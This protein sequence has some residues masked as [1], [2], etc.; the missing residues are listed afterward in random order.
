MK[1][2][3]TRR[4]GV[5]IALIAMAVA[6]LAY[7]DAQGFAG[8]VNPGTVEGAQSGRS[9]WASEA[10]GAITR[11]NLAGKLEA[12]LGDAFGGVW[13]EPTTAQLH[14]GVTSA[15][16]RRLAES[17]A[18]QVGHPDLLAVT[19]V[20]STWA[21]LD[22]AQER[23]DRRLADLMQ[24]AEVATALVAHR[25]AV[26]IE[27]G[28]SVPPSRRAALERQAAKDSV[29]VSITTDPHAEIRLIPHAQ[30]AAFKTKQA[31]CD[32]TIVGG[33]TITGPWVTKAGTEEE[34]E[35]EIEAEPEFEEEEIEGAKKVRN[36]CTAGVAAI[37][38]KPANGTEATKT[39]MLT[40]GHCINENEDGGGI[41]GKWTAYDKM[42]VP[43]GANELGSATTYLDA[44]TD[45]GVIEVKV[46]YWAKANVANPV[47]PGIAFWEAVETKPLP[48]I[49]QRNP[50]EK[51][52]TCLSGQVTIS[53]C[54]GEITTIDRSLPA[55]KVTVKN[56]IEVKGLKDALGDSGGPWFAEDEYKNGKAY[57]E[58]THVGENTGTK[59]LVFQSL[60]TSFEKLKN[61]KSLDL[62]LLT[63]A[64]ENRKHP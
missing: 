43:K 15:A 3:E 37:K 49:A 30:C 25:N 16:S 2:T 10:E 26:A 53:A 13:F 7:A 45:V 46:G 60:K 38:V 39:Y 11:T 57:A 59:N 1:S 47:V 19:P 50:V 33:V 5:L 32:P 31:V 23:W 24:R 42:G 6:A 55:G 41:G 62:E 64:N 22:A 52:K 27:L 34:G 61:E 54:G 18:A 29:D 4:S 14:V 28:S 56:L 36:R 58:G 40:A 12:A 44:E 17:V 9:P 8:D 51:M 48:V 20:D 35:F 21:A 63:T